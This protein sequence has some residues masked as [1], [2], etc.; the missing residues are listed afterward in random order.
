MHQYEKQVI[1]QNVK[2]HYSAYLGL[3]RGYYVMLNSKLFHKA[4]ISFFAGLQKLLTI[5]SISVIFQQF[6]INSLIV[7]VSILRLSTR[8]EINT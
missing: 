1:K 5:Y 3:F 2:H 6:C 7:S 8:P 4:Q